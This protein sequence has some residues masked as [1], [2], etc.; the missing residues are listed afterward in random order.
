MQI[1]TLI[2]KMLK[3]HKIHIH[4][5]GTYLKILFSSQENLQRS[6]TVR[7]VEKPDSSFWAHYDSEFDIRKEYIRQM[8]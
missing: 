6:I 2:Y 1:R 4:I 5:M 3:V 7:L 8:L